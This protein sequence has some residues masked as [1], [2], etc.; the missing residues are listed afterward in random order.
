M[1]NDTNEQKESFESSW[2]E[3]FQTRVFF[4]KPPDKQ[5]KQCFI[6]VQFARLWTKPDL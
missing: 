3:Y 5:I 1:I 4:I 6:G 2:A